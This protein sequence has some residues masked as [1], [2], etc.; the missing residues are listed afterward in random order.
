MT[1]AVE[2]TGKAVGG[3]IDVMKTQPLSLALV[4]MNAA[5]LYVLWSI[6]SGADAARKEEM[7]LIFGA[8]E[9]MQ[10]LLSKCIVPTP[11]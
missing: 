1:G 9:K 10:V 8:Q 11:N 2:E 6:Y 3:F 5:L 7:T 4:V